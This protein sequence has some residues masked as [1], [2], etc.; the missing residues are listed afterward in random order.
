MERKHREVTATEGWGLSLK[1]LASERLNRAI[2]NKKIGHDSL[3]DAIA[4][5]DLI[6]WHVVRMMGTMGSSSA[7]PHSTK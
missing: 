2:Q 3:E 5:R 6:H 7:D 4:S 1:V